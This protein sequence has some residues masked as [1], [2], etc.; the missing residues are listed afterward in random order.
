MITGRYRYIQVCFLSL[1]DGIRSR[2]FSPVFQ[3]RA[4]SLPE[5]WITFGLN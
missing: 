1:V 5:G 3:L 2:H 4:R